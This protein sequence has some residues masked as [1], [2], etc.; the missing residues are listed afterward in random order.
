[1]DLA[2]QIQIL[3]ESICISSDL[4]NLQDFVLPL[5]LLNTSPVAKKKMSSPPKKKRI[6]IFGAV[7]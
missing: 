1:M 2:T 7:C 6:Y 4:L 5:Y 3:E